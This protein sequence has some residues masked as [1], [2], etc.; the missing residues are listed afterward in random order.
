MKVASYQNIVDV[1]VQE[2][3]SA[4]A[5][6]QLCKLNGLAL[7]AELNSGDTIEVGE[8]VRK[9]VRDYL[10]SRMKGVITGRDSDANLVLPYILSESE[11]YFLADEETGVAIIQQ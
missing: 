9:G 7:D 11:A 3:G 5:L 1:A 10:K 8:P 6:V 2:Y 4:D